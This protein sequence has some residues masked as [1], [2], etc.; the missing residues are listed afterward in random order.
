[1][2]FFQLSLLPDDL[3]GSTHLILMDLACPGKTA[4]STVTVD[5]RCVLTHVDRLR[6][7]G[8]SVDQCWQSTPAHFVPPTFH[9]SV[10]FPKANPTEL[11]LVRSLTVAV[12]SAIR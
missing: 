8:L 10:G 1:M 3:C 12:T 6:P 7:D 9:G 2:R 5:T 11:I 4:S